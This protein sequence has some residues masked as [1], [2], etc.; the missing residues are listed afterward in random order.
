MENR[1]SVK[2]IFRVKRGLRIN[3]IGVTSMAR[4]K[5]TEKYVRTKNKMNIKQNEFLIKKIC[6]HK[7]TKKLGKGIKFNPVNQIILKHHDVNQNDEIWFTE[8][9]KSWKTSPVEKTN[10][11]FILELWRW[12]HS[13][14]KFISAA[15]FIV[16]FTVQRNCSNKTD[17]SVD[18]TK[19]QLQKSTARNFKVSKR[20]K[21]QR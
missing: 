6:N 15:R 3:S 12:F 1:I 5:K 4:T 2:Q 8:N 14:A 17:K 13:V 16:R 21:R 19:N 7:T 10:T 9:C 18:G 20:S 11:V